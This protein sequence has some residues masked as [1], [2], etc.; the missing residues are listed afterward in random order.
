[1]LNASA[2]LHGRLIPFP[3]DAQPFER[4]ELIGMLDVLRSGAEQAGIASCCD[5]F[6]RG[7]QFGLHARQQSID[8]EEFRLMVSVPWRIWGNEITSLDRT[9]VRESSDTVFCTTIF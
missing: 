3:H 6:H 8:N 5:H 1:M 9:Q 7:S 2:L 4:E